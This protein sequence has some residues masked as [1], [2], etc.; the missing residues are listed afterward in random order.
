VRA[1]AWQGI[2]KTALF[3]PMPQKKALE[4]VTLTLLPRP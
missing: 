4:I 2:W 3:A 1:A